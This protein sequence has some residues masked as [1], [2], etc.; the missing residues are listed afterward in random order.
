MSASTASSTSAPT[1]SIRP[2]KPA[3]SPFSILGGIAFLSLTLLTAWD[4]E[5]GV[6]LS[7]TDLIDGLQRNNSPLR[8][9]LDPDFSRIVA[10]RS[11]EA[12]LETLQMAVI[13]T[14]LGCAAALPLALLSTRIGAPNRVTYYVAKNLS[15]VIRALPDLVWAL[16][17]V[18]ALS[19]GTLPGIFALFFFSIAVT[20]KL[21]ADTVDGIDPG[22]IEAARASG[23]SHLQT[24]RTAV[25]PQ[26][27]PAYTSWALYTFELN[28]RASA[29]LGFVGA[30]GI[31]AV[32]NFHRG[33]G[34]WSEVWGI[35]V[36]FFLI[37]VVVE[38]VSVAARRRLL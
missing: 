13:G 4:W 24:L 5:Y 31:G 10:D 11:R 27:L 20:A 8:G 1:A 16:L 32:I 19:V 29:V 17:F 30:G 28:L 9:L 38:R 34:E 22:P 7:L 26:I 15:N 36:M 35:V 37:V 14:V 12:F 23:A 18:A 25:V 2:K 21:T 6:G 33:R 3:P